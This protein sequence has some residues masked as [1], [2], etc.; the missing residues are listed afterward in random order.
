MRGTYL[1][2]KSTAH[3]CTWYARRH[4]GRSHL[5]PPIRR[6]PIRRRRPPADAAAR[7]TPATPAG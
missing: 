4:A 2:R 7:P 3:L 1:H 5:R 6:P